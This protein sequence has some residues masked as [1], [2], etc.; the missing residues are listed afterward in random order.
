MAAAAGAVTGLGLTDDVLA[1]G[2][3]NDIANNNVKK[4]VTK[5]NNR[6]IFSDDVESCNQAAAL[7]VP[8]VGSIKML[9]TGNLADGT[10]TGRSII[11]IECTDG[12]IFLGAPNGRVHIR[13]KFYS[14]EVGVA[15]ADPDVEST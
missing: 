10:S 14:R 15:P 11:A 8:N 9:Q 2:I 1:S 3:P 5:S 6:L 4:I 13:S 7:I 12:D